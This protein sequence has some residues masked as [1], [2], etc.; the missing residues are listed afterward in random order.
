MTRYRYEDIAVSGL[1]PGMIVTIRDYRG[2]PATGRLF[3]EHSSGWPEYHIGVPGIG[4]R[5]S[6]LGMPMMGEISLDVEV[7]GRGM[8]PVGSFLRGSKLEDPNGEV[9]DVSDTAYLLA[10][11]GRSPNEGTS[12]VSFDR[13]HG[14]PA[15]ATPLVRLTG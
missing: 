15:P 9:L 14:K 7:H 10:D 5:L 3:L 12:W 1:E 2:R 6:K 13:V 4:W 8:I 11:G